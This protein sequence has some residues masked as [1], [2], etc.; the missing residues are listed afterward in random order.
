MT[1]WDWGTGG[2]LAFWRWCC[3]RPVSDGTYGKLS[4]H[5]GR[6]AYLEEVE[7]LESDG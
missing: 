6:K 1:T 3:G 2:I 4:V 5:Q 7:L